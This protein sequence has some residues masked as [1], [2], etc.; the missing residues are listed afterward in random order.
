MTLKLTKHRFTGFLRPAAAMAGLMVMFSTIA[1]GQVSASLLG[2]IPAAAAADAMYIDAQSRVGVGTTTPG[3]PL[4]VYRTDNTAS[5]LVE[6]DNIPANPNAPLIMF[7]LRRPGTVAFELED[8]HLA[9][10]WVFQNRLGQFTI[11]KAGTGVQELAV[12]GSGNVTIQGSLTQL[13][14]VNSKDNFD[15]V[16][17]AEVLAK[18]DSVPVL[19]W[20][21]KADSQSIR[22]LGPM[23]QDFYAAFGL[24]G[25]DRHIAPLDVAGVAI[26]GVKELHLQVQERDARLVAL[27]KE[28]EELKRRLS[29]MEETMASVLRSSGGLSA[30]T[31]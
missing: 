6:D 8:E 23:A 24:G 1:G 26:A 22:H 28:N 29:R 30:V 15:P 5:V 16:Q 17:G 4:H 9:S 14:D 11:S 21:Y 12:D 19:T 27:E 31:R 18:L 10:R 7:E 3:M 2:L 13:S 20:N 25:G